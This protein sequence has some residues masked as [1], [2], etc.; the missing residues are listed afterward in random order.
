MHD[1]QRILDKDSRKY[2]IR[3]VESFDCVLFSHFTTDEK[4][5][6]GGEVWGREKS[7]MT[8]NYKKYVI[9]DLNFEFTI[10]KQL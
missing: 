4:F 3:I 8:I 5:G 6:G 2:L 10:D 9:I 7:E 1:P